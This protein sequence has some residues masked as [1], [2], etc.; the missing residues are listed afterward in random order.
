MSDPVRTATLFI[1]AISLGLMA[2]LFYAYAG[3]VMPALRAADDRT[4]IDV[5]QRVNTAIQ[6]PLFG[7][8]FLGALVSTAAAAFQD[9]GGS[10][11]F[12]PT[13]VALGLYV[14]TLVITFAANIPLNNRLARAGNARRVD[15]PAAVRRAFFEPWVRW[16]ILRALTCAAAFAAACG[17]LVEQGRV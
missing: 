14:V 16:N 12:A 9:A 1:A 10:P 6:N 3:S 8:L 13:R 17:A 4:V 11:V 2:G 7:L 15:D 5:M